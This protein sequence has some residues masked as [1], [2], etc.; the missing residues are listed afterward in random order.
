MI[1]GWA[2][3]FVSAVT[4]AVKCQVSVDARLHQIIVTVALF[5]RFEVFLKVEVYVVYICILPLVLTVIEYVLEID[6]VLGH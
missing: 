4:V 2:A 5:T 6:V 3:P 1:S